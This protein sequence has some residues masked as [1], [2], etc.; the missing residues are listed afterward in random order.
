MSWTCLVTG[1]TGF[2]GSHLAE[3]LVARG[4]QVLCLI[5]KE[6]NL[7]WLRHLP[8]EYVRGDVEAADLR[9]V[10]RRVDY[11]YHAAGLTRALDPRQYHE[12]NA[13]GCR[14]MLEV[15]REAPRLRRFLLVSSLAAV[16]PCR[17]G[18]ILTEDAPPNPIT[19]Y[20]RSKLAAEEIA[21]QFMASVPVTVVRPPTIYGPRDENSLLLFRLVRR[22]VRPRFLVRAEHSV[23]HVADLVEGAIRA[24]ESVVAAGRT[25]FIADPQS[26]QL[27]EL[28]DA[29]VEALGVRAREVP[30]SPTVLRL[31][32]RLAEL[33]ARAVGAPTIFDRYKVEEMLQERWVCDV[34]RAREELGFEAGVS[35]AVGVRETARWYYEAGWL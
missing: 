5:R 26:Y 23:V 11:V 8:V 13:E 21:A 1:A 6:S 31:G 20:G 25:Y 2:V 30:I 9:E 28:V 17:E 4:Y 22:G 18:K 24:A 33:G 16:G 7:R 19:P 3:H 12:V 14:R 15:C 34:S 35:L 32:A 29:V 27:N 10:V